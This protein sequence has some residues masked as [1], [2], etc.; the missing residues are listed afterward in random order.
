VSLTEDG[1]PEVTQWHRTG[2]FA[3]ERSGVANDRQADRTTR[4]LSAAVHFDTKFCTRLYNEFLAV[5]FRAVPPSPGLDSAAVL[6]EAAA[7][8][9]RRR[10]RDVLSLALMVLL[11]VMAP[12]LLLGWLLIA[13]LWRQVRV[14]KP[15]YWKFI[16]RRP[17]TNRWK[18]AIFVLLGLLLLPVIGTL[19][20]GLSTA[21]SILF[22]L[23]GEIPVVEVPHVALV[24]PNALMIVVSLYAVFAADRLVEWWL[25][26]RSFR[27][28]RFSARPLFEA[29]PGER[30]ARTVNDT[31]LHGQ[32]DQIARAA[33]HG[34]IIVYSGKDPFVGAGYPLERS[35]WSMAIP[36]QPKSAPLDD[37][38]PAEESLPIPEGEVAPQHQFTPSEM[39]HYVR[40]QFDDLR[41]S[42]SLAPS[43]R[44]RE[45][46]QHSMLIAEATELLRHRVDGH[47]LARA[48]LPELGTRPNATM[49]ESFIEQIADDPVEWIRQF[50]LF[51][52]ESWERDLVVSG[53]LHL[54]CDNRML[55]VEWNVFVLYPI[56][57]RFWTVDL[58]PDSP[59]PALRRAAG[60]LLA[61]PATVPSRLASLRRFE[62]RRD[63]SVYWAPHYGCRY[64]IRE[65]AADDEADSYFQF[66][67]IERYRKILERHAVASMMKFLDSKGLST[68]EF[69]E[70][71]ATII[72]NSGSMA[73]NA[74]TII[75][76]M[77]GRDV[78]TSTGAGPATPT[79]PAK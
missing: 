57:P 48:V 31:Y 24:S 60:D 42:L 11:L 26:T 5:P 34:N 30:L 70:R 14:S 50:T 68:A 53:F 79:P 64:S 36:L 52:V 49:P 37:L 75:G 41:S 18:L 71:A 10:L 59:W 62:P 1:T 69:A 67:D 35:C 63:L 66:T 45:L 19:L 39:H 28:G 51:R 9:T 4:R 78:N 13:V 15:P 3:Q 38:R 20:Q 72:N 17:Q 32:I 23:G 56:H 22:G 44:L 25:A 58:V 7:A 76:S 33:D 43:D 46:T 27:A 8:M 16:G 21:S 29:W 74:G 12:F 77:A 47:P 2:R 54:G 61:C 65:L 55:Y 73:L 40:Q 6:R